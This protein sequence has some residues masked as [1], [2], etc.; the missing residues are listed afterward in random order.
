MRRGR[1]CLAMLLLCDATNFIFTCVP[2]L[3]VDLTAWA[4]REGSINAV[5]G[6]KK[7]ILMDH[8]PKQQRGRWNA[9]DS[10]QG[11]IWS[12]AA[13]LGGYLSHA[14]GYRTPLLCMSAGFVLA[15]VTFVPVSRLR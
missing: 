12:A 10:L 2:V 13:V 3:A 4:V 7:S 8:T 9:V 15:T 14:F 5:F 11:G 6:L 1:V